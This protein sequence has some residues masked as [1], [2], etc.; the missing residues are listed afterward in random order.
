MKLVYVNQNLCCLHGMKNCNLYSKQCI[1]CTSPCLASMEL[2]N[3]LRDEISQGGI[4][5]QQPPPG[6]NTI[7]LV[8]KLLRRQFIEITETVTN[9]HLF[10]N[11]IP[12]TD[13]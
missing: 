9:I 4:A 11:Y 7:C 5:E 2:S 3:Y 12:I 13:T 1:G 6:S 8:L 10:K